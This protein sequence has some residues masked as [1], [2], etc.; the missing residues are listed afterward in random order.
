[1]RHE[2]A[3]SI[4]VLSASLVVSFGKA[5]GQPPKQTGK[6]PVVP[7]RKIHIAKPDCSTGQSCHGI[8]GLVALNVDVLTDG[9]VGEVEVTEAG[10]DQR[11]VDAA[12]VAAKKCRFEPGTLN[13][14]PTSMNF[15]LKYKF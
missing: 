5:H 1:M 13:G 2:R 7:P 6:L 8:H 11:L 10:V 9:T 4:F 15:V 3:L 14:K 12:T